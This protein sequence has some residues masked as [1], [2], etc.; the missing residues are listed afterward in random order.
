ME[1][2]PLLLY[3]EHTIHVNCYKSL[4]MNL[5]EYSAHL[6]WKFEIKIKTFN[7]IFFTFQYTS[8]EPLPYHLDPSWNL[9]TEKLEKYFSYITVRIS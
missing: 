9:L 5:I 8:F 4:Q 2:S 3:F 1:D 6:R 7:C